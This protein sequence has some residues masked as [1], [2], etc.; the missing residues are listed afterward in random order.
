MTHFARTLFPL[1]KY[2]DLAY[3]VMLGQNVR[4]NYKPYNY[5]EYVWVGG[6][7]GGLLGWGMG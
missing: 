6:S 4:S 7:E 3:L 5:S 1:Q 2:S